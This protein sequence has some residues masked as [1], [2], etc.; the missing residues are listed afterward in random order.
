MK[1]R[2]PLIAL[3]VLLGSITASHAQISVGIGLPGINIGI[4]VPVYPNLVLIPGYPVYYDPRANANYFFYDGLYWVYQDDDWYASSWYNGPWQLI[5][6]EYVPVFLLRIPVRYY[7]HPPAYFRN[8][9][10]DAP[11]RWGDHWGRDWEQRRNGWDRWDRRAVP[12]AAP[13]PLYQRQYSGNRYP[14]A[15]ERQHAIRSEKYRYQ[16]RDP[17]TREHFEQRGNPDHSRARQPLQQQAPARQRESMQQQQN[18]QRQ[19]QEQPLQPPRMQRPQP[20]PQSRMR[21]NSP[22]PRGRGHENNAELQD[23]ARQHRMEPQDRVRGN[24]PEPQGRGRENK[25]ELQD[26]GRG[27]RSEERDQDRR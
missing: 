16:P 9:R 25:A 8:W 23:R 3:S 12:R 10:A 6:P 18:Q 4:N 1:I 20:E 14:R 27:N 22:E 19:Q 7:R 26:K 17:V 5:Q 24:N 15:A 11:P 21:E 13:L 2:Y